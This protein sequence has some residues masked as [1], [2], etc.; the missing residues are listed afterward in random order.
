LWRVFAITHRI[1][2]ETL[3]PPGS[4]NN[5]NYADRAT[6]EQYAKAAINFQLAD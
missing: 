2:G 1:T 6:A 3:L 5:V 4:F